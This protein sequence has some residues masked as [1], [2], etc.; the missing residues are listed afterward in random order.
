MKLMPTTNLILSFFVALILVISAIKDE[1]QKSRGDEQKKSKKFNIF[2]LGI[3]V[4]I[5]SA[6]ILIWT[7][8]IPEQASA[9]TDEYQSKTLSQDSVIQHKS[10][11]L[12]LL[13]ILLTIL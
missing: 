2:S 9:K 1:K 10:D 5:A 11:R 4:A 3:I 8:I 13:A 6:I 7:S 12:L